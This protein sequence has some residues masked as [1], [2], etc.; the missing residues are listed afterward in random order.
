MYISRTE[1]EYEQYRREVYTV[2]KPTKLKK[3]SERSIELKA[4]GHTSVGVL[5]HFN[6]VAATLETFK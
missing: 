4:Y 1:R 2:Y 3:I 5:R 6:L